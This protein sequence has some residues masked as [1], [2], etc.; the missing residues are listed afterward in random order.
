MQTIIRLTLL[1]SLS[2]GLIWAQFAHA[3]DDV[4]PP[5]K[6]DT[7]SA[8]EHAMATESADEGSDFNLN[9]DLAPPKA[10][11]GV[12][13]RTYLREGDKAQITEYSSHGRVFLI[14]V[15]PLGGLPAYYLEDDDGD[16]TLNKRLPGGY[17]HISPPMWVIKRF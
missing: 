1:C 5:P 13:I 17:K 15:Q 7:A 8:H 10:G 9:K 12:D 16:G 6:H 11:D 4:S 3:G 14:K 2:L